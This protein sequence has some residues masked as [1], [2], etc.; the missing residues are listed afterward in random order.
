MINKWLGVQAMA[1]KPTALEDVKALTT[2]EG[3]D[4]SNPNAFRS[5]INAFAAGNPAAF[6]KKD[7]SGYEFIADQVIEVDKRNPQVAARLA[8]S[9]NAWRR[10]DEGRQ[11]LMKAQLER[12]A[13]QASS[14][15]TKEIVS[16]TLA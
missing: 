2:H 13:E 16:R 5:L 4:A 10:H 3:Y 8:S 1:D 14:K 12:I 9:F 7:G 6:H 11:A 15:D